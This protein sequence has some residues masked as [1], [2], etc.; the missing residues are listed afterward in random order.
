MGDELL[1]VHVTQE[2]LVYHLFKLFHIQ[3]HAT[4]PLRCTS[5]LA[6]LSQLICKAT[7]AVLV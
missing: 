2:L 6:T 3:I 5:P 1:F 4:Q 7:Q